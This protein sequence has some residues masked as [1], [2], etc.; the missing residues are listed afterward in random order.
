MQCQPLW[1]AV[2]HVES[3]EPACKAH[4]VFVTPTG[5]PLTQR[6]AEELAGKERLLLICGHYEGFDQRVLERLRD[7]GGLD[8]I[9]VGDV[10]LSGG[11]LPAMTVMDAV[12]RLL[13]G[14]LGDAESARQ[15]SF[16][17]GVGRLLDHPHY[18]GPREW[19]GR[20][21][22]EVL[23]SGNH[24]K[25]ETWRKAQ[26]RELTE[27]RRPD[28]LTGGVGVGDSLVVTVREAAHEGGELG[29][30]EAVHTAAFGGMTHR[31][32]VVGRCTNRGWR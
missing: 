4:R 30:I 18:T 2:V 7:E 21:V 24:G 3:E 8:E 25:I 11:E 10:V 12:V 28:L 20:A 29:E 9:S 27:A 19:E 32:G 31:R 23:L 5:R 6:V 14:A 17:P 1:D 16:S 26:S 15:D 13:P 22:P